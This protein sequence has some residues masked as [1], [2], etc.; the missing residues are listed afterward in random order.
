VLEQVQALPRVEGAGVIENFFISGAP[1]QLVTTEGRTENLRFRSDAVSDGFFR[2]IGTP[3]LRGR[4]F[5]VT[6][7]PDSSRVAIVNEA[8]ARRLW[9]GSEPVGKRLKLGFP[10]SDSPWFTIVGVVGDMRRQGL[11]NEPMPQMFESLAQNP[12][13]LA[14]LLVKTSTDE[15]MR[16]AGSVRAAVR[17][18]EKY[19]PVY[20]ATTLESKL[21]GFLTHRRFQ[22]SLLV[23]FAV[24]ALLMS[25]IGI[26]G[27]IQYSVTART[28]EIGIRMALGANAAKIFRMTIGEGLKLSLIGL[29]F[30][31]VGA[32]WLGRVGSSLLFGVI[33][34]DP[35]TFITV[36]VLL[37]AVA[38][39]AC[40][41]P[42]RRAMK[43]EPMVALR[44]S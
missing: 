7:G 39:A 1:E 17:R 42:A 10:D 24:A 8:M 40:Y 4:L 43:V 33:A 15:P 27:L 18:V 21:G 20:F 13:R 22:T 41:F 31:L 12:S 35:L 38:V 36:S 30:G 44:A 16:L 34:I 3:L 32:F 9:P 37:T 29:G 28:Q 26:Y 6:D 2:P 19:A 5:S 11:E 14:T 23:G 25:A